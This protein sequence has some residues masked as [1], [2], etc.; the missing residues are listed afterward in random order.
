MSGFSE[1]YLEHFQ[2]PR[3]VGEVN[4]PSVLVEVEHEG[5]GCFDRLRLT[6]KVEDGIIQEVKFKARACSGTIAASSAATEWATGKSVE[7]IA[8]V[9]SD[10]LSDY[11]GGV[12]DKKRHSMD[13]AAKALQAIATKINE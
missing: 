10:F 3:N 7:E 1:K 2:A 9:T 11:L 8:E 6:A 5:G 4:E 13:L 12:P